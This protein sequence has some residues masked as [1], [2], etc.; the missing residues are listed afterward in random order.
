[1]PSRPETQR[2]HGSP[3][4]TPTRERPTTTPVPT[5]EDPQAAAGPDV[6]RRAGR[7]QPSFP[8]NGPPPRARPITRDT[9]PPGPEGGGGLLRF[10]QPWERC[11]GR[12]SEATTAQPESTPHASR[13]AQPRRGSG[14]DADARGRDARDGRHGRGTGGTGGTGSPPPP[15]RSPS[16]SDSLGVSGEV[17]RTR[18]RARSFP[19]RHHQSTQSSGAHGR[20][21]SSAPRNPSPNSERGGAGRGRRE[22]KRFAQKAIAGVPL[23]GT[24]RERPPS[25]PQSTPFSPRI[26][27]EGNFLTEGGTIPTTTS[28][29][30]RELRATGAGGL[31]HQ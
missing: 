1:M 17:P 30:H 15:F 4:K 9:G 13:A 27:R 2:P 12:G 22:S 16:R 26:A 18:A 8:Q 7:D 6:R 14:Q 23:E 5:A 20:T 10:H 28:P 19:H 11:R 21:T 24:I 31:R 3:S 29:G 25:R